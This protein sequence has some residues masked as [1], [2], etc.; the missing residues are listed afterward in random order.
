M[1]FTSHQRSP[2]T[3]AVS[4]VE[5]TRDQR[6]LVRQ[7]RL[8]NHEEVNHLAPPTGGQASNHPPLYDV[9][10]CSI[11]LK[12]PVCCLRVLPANERRSFIVKGQTE[13]SHLALHLSTRH[14]ARTG[15]PLE[16][17]QANRATR[18]TSPSAAP[19]LTCF[20]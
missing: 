16:M 15:P 7:Q 2:C 14:P 1:G 12:V 19:R 18:H 10:F 17:S 3:A 5:R 6:R 11:M 13:C 4:A 9:H 8:E 20:C